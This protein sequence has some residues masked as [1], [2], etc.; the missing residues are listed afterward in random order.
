MTLFTL[1]KIIHGVAIC[2]LFIT[3][4][5]QTIILFRKNPSLDISNLSSRKKIVILQHSAFGIFL[6]TGGWLLY[7]KGFVVQNWFYAKAILFVVL[8]SSLIKAF[9]KG[10]G[11]ILPAQRRGG[12]VLAWIAFI[13]ILILVAIKPN[14]F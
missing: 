9:K 4:V 2:L 10:T 6:I 5:I 1:L 8:L 3:L 11:E 13:A 12:V 7:L 14:L